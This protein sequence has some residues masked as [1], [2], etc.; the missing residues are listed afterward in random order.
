MSKTLYDEAIAEA[1]QLR[2]LAE[3]NAK[4]AIVEAVTPKIRKF[5][6]DQLIS[7]SREDSLELSDSAQN[8]ISE[9]SKDK[10]DVILDESA[11]N[12]L[13]RLTGPVDEMDAHIKQRFFNAFSDSANLIG[14][15]RREKL[16]EIAKKLQNDSGTLS[17]GGI[18][19][20]QELNSIHIKE[21]SDMSRNRETLYEVDLNDIVS[22][23]Y[24]S[25][26]PSHGDL[27][28]ESSI[29]EM[30]RELE[31][32]EAGEAYDPLQEYDL[33]F[34]QDE[35]E[36]EVE[37]EEVEEEAPEGELPP[38]DEPEGGELPPDVEER[39]DDLEDAIMA[40]LAGGGGEAPEGAEPEGL[41]GLE[42]L[43]GGEG[44]ESPE[45]LAEVLD[46][47]LNML[48]SEIRRMKR[49][50]ETGRDTDPDAMEEEIYYEEGDKEQPPVK[51]ENR[52]LRRAILNQGRSNRAMR[53]KL[54][55]Y[56]SA[57]GSLREQ[58]TEMNLFNAKL[59]YVNKML[60]NRDVSSAQRR[61]V[62]EALD[63]ARSLR[64]VKLLYKSLTESIGNRKSGRTLTESAVRRNLGSASRTTTQSSS[65][66]SQ[67]AEVG[68]WAKLAGITE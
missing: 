9:S 45:E 38:M 15:Q 41:E 55:E 14:N 65:T 29:R 7:E 40:A 64:E 36:S 51:E 21:N 4:Q 46:V 20:D 30:L 17:S 10:D 37:E 25:T 57:V 18:V 5:I 50:S 3:K 66:N 58:L 11:L 52:K 13:L 63:S 33:F 22:S 27:S 42:D 8:L 54:D 31:D 48:K 2:E 60:Q 39:L 43:E 53:S 23:L 44:E 24:E 59:L 34:E 32:G 1:R 47:D 62:I 6:E 26:E 49:L 67:V 61:S 68:R 16:L 35:P 12:T 19:I 56:R 28:S